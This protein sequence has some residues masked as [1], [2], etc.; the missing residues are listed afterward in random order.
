MKSE[1]E[2]RLDDILQWLDK[3]PAKSECKIYYDGTKQWSLR[4]KPYIGFFNG[5]ETLMRDNRLHREDG[6]AL[7]A[8][9][10]NTYW[11]KEHKEWHLNGRLYIETI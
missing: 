4:S 5:E 10:G 11:I 9:A 3:N 6:P 7:I 2:E 8:P 1:C